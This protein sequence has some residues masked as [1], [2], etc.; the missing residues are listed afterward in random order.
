MAKIIDGPKGP[1]VRNRFSPVKEVLADTT[2][3]TMAQQNAKEDTDINKI[4][5]RYQK[6]IVPTT[7]VPVFG[8]TPS[9]SF[10]EMLNK[11]MDIDN[12]FEDL[13]AKVRVRFRNDPYQLLRFIEDKKNWPEA[14][15]LGLMTVPD[16]YILRE[17]GALDEVKPVVAPVTE[18]KVPPQGGVPNGDK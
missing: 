4:V 7:K 1:E 6:G 12:A 9:L 2:G 16:G 3:E 14:V 15:K 8:N 17:D 13:P 10:H 5:E 18:V 11:V